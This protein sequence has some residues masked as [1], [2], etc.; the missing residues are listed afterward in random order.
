MKLRKTLAVLSAFCL[1]M[2]GAAVLPESVLSEVSLTVSAASYTEGTYESLTYRLYD[3]EGYVT[4]YKADASVSG[5]VTIPSEIEGLPVTTIEA[6]AFSGCTSLK[7]VIIPDSVTYIGG[8]DSWSNYGAFYG[9]TSLTDVTVGN[10]VETIGRSAFAGCTA[11]KNVTFG[12]GLKTIKKEAF[13][14]CTALKDF[15]LPSGVTV[16]GE[17]AFKSCESLTSVT[18]PDT[19]TEIGESAFSGCI[20]L[21]SAEINGLV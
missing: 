4:I 6:Q 10:S 21:K 15:V 20:G 12:S 13:S 7:S 9:C 1:L 2:T 19:M 17:S 11:L 8:N 18:I 14:G 3:T 5:E 16:I